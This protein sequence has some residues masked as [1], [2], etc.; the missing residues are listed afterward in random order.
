MS[1]QIGTGETIEEQTRTAL[2]EV[3]HALLK[4]GSDKSRILE[5][6]IWLADMERD[7]DRMNVVYDQWIIPGKPPCRACI[8]A[9]L[10]SKDWKVEI[11]AIAA[12]S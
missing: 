2:E 7:Y 3:S 9:P 12:K 10:A 5:L 6:T 4:A 8:Q 11:R 1:G